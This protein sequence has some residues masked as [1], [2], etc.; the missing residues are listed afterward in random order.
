MRQSARRPASIRI[1]H[2][3]TEG[4]AQAGLRTRKREDVVI[5]EVFSADRLPA[6]TRSGVMIRRNLLTVAGA[7]S[8]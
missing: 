1:A 5:D 7:V 4:R 6:V 8:G 3:N 2:R